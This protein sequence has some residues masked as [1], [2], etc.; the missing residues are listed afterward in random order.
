MTGT[1]CR[2]VRPGSIGSRIEKVPLGS[3]P[4]PEGQE[5][6]DSDRGLH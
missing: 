1:D 3:H 5:T 2:T 4:D 6:S